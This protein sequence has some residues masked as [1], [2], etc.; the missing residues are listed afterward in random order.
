MTTIHFESGDFGTTIALDMLPTL[1]VSNVRKILKILFS[2]P[3]QNRE[4]IGTITEWIPDAVAGAKNAYGHAVAL[5]KDGWRVVPK[6]YRSVGA[7]E[8]RKKNRQLAEAVKL[9]RIAYVQLSKFRSLF[10]EVAPL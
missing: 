3:R 2:D 10:Q 9:A 7:T 8:Q 1:P 6:G 4:A 5:Y